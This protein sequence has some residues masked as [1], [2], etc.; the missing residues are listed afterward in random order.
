MPVSASRVNELPTTF[1][2]PIYR[3]AARGGR[4]SSAG[5]SENFVG[6]VQVCGFRRGV[7]DCVFVSRWGYTAVCACSSP[8]PGTV[9]SG[10]R[11]VLP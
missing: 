2:C 7:R 11:V 5:R 6:V 10:Y 8:L 3:T 4:L 1:E 9:T